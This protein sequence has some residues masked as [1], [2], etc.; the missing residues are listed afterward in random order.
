M[1]DILIGALIML[2]VC[3][4]AF[5]MGLKATEHRSRRLGNLV[6]V[7]V[8][9]LTIAYIVFL[10]DH[11]VLTRFIPWSNVILLG[12]WFPVGAAILSGIACGRLQDYPARRAVT[13]VTMLAVGGL[14]LF[15][16]LLGFPPECRDEWQGQNC[17]QTS[18]TSCMAAAA[19]T[20]LKH[21]G[22]E[23]SE[24]EMAHLCF[25]R[26]GTNWLGLYH[27]IAVKLQP[28]QLGPV[29]FDGKLEQLLAHDGPQI[30]SC[31]ISDE[32]ARKYP[33]YKADWG[34]IPGVKHAVVLLRAEDDWLYIAD[35]AVGLETWAMDDL[36]ILWDGRGLRVEPLPGYSGSSSPMAVSR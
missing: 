8:L 18:Q 5:V 29:L 28:V 27:G 2:A 4:L 10:W 6:G 36:R 26:K 25:T 21:Y 19:A 9:L 33:H 16:P 35:P 23:S 32:V 31:G 15:W 13:A 1:T 22:V 7:C 17:L 34:W 14:G 20:V 24:Q 12:N 30:I 11:A 3:S